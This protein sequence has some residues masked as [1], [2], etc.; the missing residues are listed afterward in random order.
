MTNSVTE[1]AIEILRAT[2][3]GNELSPPHL[4][5]V[6]L[7]VNGFLNEAGTAAFEELYG[8]ATK[9]AGYTVPWFHGIEHLTRDHAGYIRWKGITVE[10][11]DSPWYYTEPARK[12]AQETA[13][14]CKLLESIGEA[15]TNQKVIWKWEEWQKKLEGVGLA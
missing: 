15:P 12:A 13:D 11:Y 14:R 5:L 1:M 6:E 2:N 10:H 4:K 9:S 8:N 3:D 7:A